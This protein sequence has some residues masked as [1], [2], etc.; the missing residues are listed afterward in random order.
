MM[1]GMPE[2]RTHDYFRHGVTSLFAAFDITTEEFFWCGL[3]LGGMVGIDIATRAASRISRLVLCSTSGYVQ[4][5]SVWRNR[6]DEIA[7]GGTERIASSVVER[8]FTREWA[9]RH[10]NEVNAARRWVATTD[11]IGYTRCAEAIIEWDH[12]YRLKDISAPTLVIAG[13]YDSATPVHPDADNLVAG[14]KDA[15]L[16]V[17]PGAHLPTIECPSRAN[18]AIVEHLTGQGNVH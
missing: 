1:P 16:V 12:L 14:I 3:S 17:F 8:W 18:A 10:P 9:E 15:R 11:D 6:I 13:Q 7:V 5:T 4:D 2:R